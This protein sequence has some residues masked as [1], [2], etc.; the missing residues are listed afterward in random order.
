MQRLFELKSLHVFFKL[1]FPSPPQ[2]AWNVLVD[3]PT[4]VD[5]IWLEKIGDVTW[6]CYGSLWFSSFAE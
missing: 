4:E 6:D 1:G 3:L 5:G 2:V